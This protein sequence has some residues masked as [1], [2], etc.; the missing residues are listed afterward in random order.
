MDTRRLAITAIALAA[1]L[2]AWADMPAPSPSPIAMGTDAP[3]RICDV[4]LS[5]ALRDEAVALRHVHQALRD[6]RH[7]A[8]HWVEVRELPLRQEAGRNSFT[9]DWTAVLCGAV[10]GYEEADNAVTANFSCS[11]RGFSSAG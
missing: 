5:A 7:E 1:A 11:F 2:T 10:P 8:G 9:P 3:T 6:Q 4:A